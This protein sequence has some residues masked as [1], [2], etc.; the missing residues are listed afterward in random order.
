MTTG[1]LTIPGFQFRGPL[2]FTVT[3]KQWSPPRTV[4]CPDCKGA[5]HIDEW[6]GG[7]EMWRFICKLCRGAGKVKLVPLEPGDH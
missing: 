5:G 2:T 4:D 1:P 3:P 7:S 6:C